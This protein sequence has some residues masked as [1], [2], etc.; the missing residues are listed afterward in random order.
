MSATSKRPY[1]GKSRTR[2]R[3]RHP[4]VEKNQEKTLKIASCILWPVAIGCALLAGSQLAASC[5][6]NPTF[7]DDTQ[8]DGE[9]SDVILPVNQKIGEYFQYPEYP[10]G[11][12][13]ASTCIVMRAY[14]DWVHIDDLLGKY[15]QVSNSDYIY[16]YYGNIYEN[17]FTFPPA[18]ANTINL[19][20]STN[21]S[22]YFAQ[23]ISF[24][25]W[26]EYTNYLEQGYPLISWGTIDYKAP[27]WGTQGPGQ[28]HSYW[29]LHCVVVYDIDDEYVYISDPIEGKI[30][31]EIETWKSIWEEC[32]KY[33]VLV[34]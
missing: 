8:M 33:A 26:D 21:N 16:S 10:A 11:C 5:S 22:S 23:D 18:I 27:R 32:G 14:G 4:R 6:T 34:Q 15:I 1:P 25:S 19:Y 20:S 17:G 9:I 31:I 28:Y 3:F 29:N 13:L 2:P 30:E 12:E 7:V 24:C